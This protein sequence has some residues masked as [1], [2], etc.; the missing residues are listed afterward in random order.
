MQPPT[1]ADVEARVLDL[2]KEWDNK[3]LAPTRWRPYL[4]AS[5]NIA[6]ITYSHT[7]LDVQVH[8]TLFT[9][10]TIAIDEFEVSDED[11][12]RFT[13][14]LLSGA[15][16]SD[17]LL[18]CLVDNLRHMPDYFPSYAYKC[19]TLSTMDFIDATLHDKAFINMDLRPDALPYVNN[20]RF[21]SGLGTAY[22]LF[23]WDKFSF[24]DISTYV[25]VIP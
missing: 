8:I 14:R 6:T 19:I 4:E 25:Q 2:T 3:G 11:L 16:Q 24:P 13:A 17:P 7:R 20:K 15:P 5:L 9:A 18:D 10:L 22:G 1:R 12:D 21:R 23:I